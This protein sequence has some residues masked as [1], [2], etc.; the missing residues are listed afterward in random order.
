MEQVDLAANSY[1]EINADREVWVLLL[2][3]SAKFDLLQAVPGEALFVEDQQV[4]V[5]A[6]AGAVKALVAY[7]ASDPV[8][9][10]L[11]SRNGETQE[12]LVSRFPEL[13]Q[14]CELKAPASTHARGIRS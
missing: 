13:G 7:V 6:G 1:W 9:G 12:A 10:L 4:R 2:E 14:G 8:A 3:G 5:H 11:Q